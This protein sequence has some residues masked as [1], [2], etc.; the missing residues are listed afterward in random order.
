MKKSTLTRLAI[1]VPAVLL[2]LFIALTLFGRSV[3]QRPLPWHTAWAAAFGKRGWDQGWRWSIWNGMSK[4][5]V[6]D[7]LGD[8]DSVFVNRRFFDDGG[9]DL[10][11]SRPAERWFYRT[12]FSTGTLSGVTF[13]HGRV[14]HH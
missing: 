5:Q 6:R 3:G 11:E 10:M 14:V 12:P 8:P 4:Q 1:R 13:H 7:M 2:V 9:I